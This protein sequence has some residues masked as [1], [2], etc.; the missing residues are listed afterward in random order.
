MGYFTYVDC[1]A[2]CSLWF[3]HIGLRICGGAQLFGVFPSSGSRKHF[4][5]FLGEIDWS[6]DLHRG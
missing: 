6:K 1:K 4:T 2:T 3:A 5:H